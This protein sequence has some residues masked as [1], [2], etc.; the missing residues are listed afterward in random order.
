M[1]RHRMSLA[2]AH[3]LDATRSFD[4]G[5]GVEKQLLHLVFKIQYSFFQE[6]KK[7]PKNI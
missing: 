3:I 2:L 5:I 4:P 1:L 7:Q 6:S